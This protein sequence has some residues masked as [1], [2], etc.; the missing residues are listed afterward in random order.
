MDFEIEEEWLKIAE[1]FVNGYKR[2]YCDML[3]VRERLI[4]LRLKYDEEHEALAKNITMVEDRM[5]R[6]RWTKVDRFSIITT[7]GLL[8]PLIKKVHK[9]EHHEDDL[10]RNEVCQRLVK[11]EKE[12]LPRIDKL[13]KKIG[14]K[15]M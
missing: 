9:N 8:Y 12:I 14:D 10:I 2:E 5:G 3:F 13:I 7:G 1:Y 15:S 4:R 6:S 11:L